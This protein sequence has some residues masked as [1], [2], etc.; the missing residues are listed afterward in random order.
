MIIATWLYNKPWKPKQDTLTNILTSIF[1]TLF[2]QHHTIPPIIDPTS[3]IDHFPIDAT[4]SLPPPLSNT[5]QANVTTTIPPPITPSPIRPP[6]IQLSFFDGTDP[7][8][9][10]F[11]ADKLTSAQL[12]ER[13]ATSFCYNCDAKK[14]PGHKCNS[15]RFLLLLSEDTTPEN[16]TDTSTHNFSNLNPTTFSN[17]EIDDTTHISPIITSPFRHP[18]IQYF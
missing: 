16:P 13:R 11:Q 5:S 1:T 12:Q 3:S 18:F 9:W 17:P 6:K 7:L 10:L 8:D 4:T 14:F 2:A 15:S